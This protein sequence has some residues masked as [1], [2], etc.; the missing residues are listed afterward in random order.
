[1]NGLCNGV[2]CRPRPFVIAVYASLC[3]LRNRLPAPIRYT[4]GHMRPSR[5]LLATAALA[6]GDIPHVADFSEASRRSVGGTQPRILLAATLRWPLAARLAIAF[7][8]LSCRVEAWCPA[9]HPLEKTRAVERI[10]RCGTLAPLRSLAAAINAAAP[11]IIIPCDDDAAI[12]LHRLYARGGTDK[13]S[14]TLRQVIERS[15]GTPASCLLA[16]AR[17]KLMR[18]AQAEGVRVPETLW[19]GSSADLDDWASRSGF[20]AVLKVDRSWGGLGVSIVHDIEQARDAYRMATH[21]ST[22]RALSHLILRRDASYLLRQLSGTR[23]VVTLQKF[24]A[25][26]PANC[27][28]ACW[29]GEVMAATSVIALQTQTPTG[30]A[31]VVRVIENAEM[32]DAVKRLVR[33]LRLSGLCGLDFVVEAG[34][35][36]AYL[37]EMN[38]R[39]TPIS[40]LALGAGHDLPAAL[41]ARLRGEPA[42][43]TASAIH[44]S[45]I[46]MFP[47]EWRRDPQSA[48]LP[49][50]Y[51]DVPWAEM[52]LVRDC[53]ERPWEERGLA[54]QI[55]AYLKPRRAPDFVLAP[56]ERA[57]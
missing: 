35:G 12:H 23:P 16:T 49:S 41:N 26:A 32:S 3:T 47:G 18:L 27:A 56:P 55:R 46:A 2:L 8:E 44:G 22:L 17:G 29:Q 53:V 31:T 11:G 6:D 20:P 7:R 38:P 51:H 4:V 30:P 34:T 40:H 52:E 13:S 9:G 39:A 1:M 21:P 37:I 57:P 28:V 48:F 24:I 43:M 10:Y 36:A 19:L 15:L 14:V 25:G 54:A 5:E 42:P 50:A 45:V 33:S